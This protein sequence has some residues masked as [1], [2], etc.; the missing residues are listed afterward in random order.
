MQPT[1]SATWAGGVPSV[2]TRGELNEQNKIFSSSSIKKRPIR[3]INRF[4][5]ANFPIFPSAAR[6]KIERNTETERKIS[7]NENR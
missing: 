4:L 5:S 7:N 3:R 1:P 2:S 6:E